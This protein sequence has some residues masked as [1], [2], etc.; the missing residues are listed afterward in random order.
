MNRIITTPSAPRLTTAAQAVRLIVRADDMGSSHA[1]NA[2][3]LDSCL[4]GIVRTVEVMPVCAWFPE[5]AAWLRQHQD[6]D[7]GV[8]LTLTS[9]WDQCK[10]RPLTSVPSLVN[11]DGFFYSAIWPNPA[12]T[13]LSALREQSWQLAEIESEWRAQIELAQRWIPQVSHLSAHMGCAQMDSQV[14][15]LALQ[16]AN[17]YGLGFELEGFTVRSL[18]LWPAG[19]SEADWPQAFAE[20]LETLTAGIYLF[21]E[22]PGLDCA[23]MQNMGNPKVAVKRAAV[24]RTFTDPAVLDAVRQRGIQLIRYSD[25]YENKS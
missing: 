16:L 22:H 14:Q 1:A 4:H 5:A 20:I 6:F 8:H 3:C 7:V 25:L 10:W 24:T 21:V 23:E 17:E 18:P 12:S 15:T 9:E 13:I 2:A 11:R 19:L